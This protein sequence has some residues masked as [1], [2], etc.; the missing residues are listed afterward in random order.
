MLFGWKGCQGPQARITP[1]S[2]N[3][4]QLKYYNTSDLVYMGMGD[5]WAESVMVPYGYTLTLFDLDGQRPSG[6][7][8]VQKGRSLD[9]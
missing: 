6:K 8:E 2:N 9:A 4:Q 5:D 3:P 1:S 7:F